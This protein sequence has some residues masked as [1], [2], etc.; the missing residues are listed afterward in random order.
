MEKSNLA[1]FSNRRESSHLCF[2]ERKPYASLYVADLVRSYFYGW[3][4]DS[5]SQREIIF[6]PRK[7][8]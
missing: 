5:P 4:V 7:Y 8:V 1:T 3:R 6:P 2:F